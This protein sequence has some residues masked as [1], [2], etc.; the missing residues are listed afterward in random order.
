MG[1]AEMIQT[2][3]ANPNE[4]APTFDIDFSLEGARLTSANPWPRE[5]LNVDAES[6]EFAMYLE[7]AAADGRF[8][9]YLK[10]VME[11]LKVFDEDQE[12]EGPFRKAWEA[13][14]QFGARI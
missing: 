4:E 8:E 7:A 2:G 13:L 14:V 9:G 12:S 11:D 10:P 1:E 6:G 3:D 5:F